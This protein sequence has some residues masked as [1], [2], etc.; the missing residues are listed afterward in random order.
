MKNDITAG[1]FYKGHEIL[2]RL[3]GAFL[4]SCE[5]DRDRDRYL[6]FPRRMRPRLREVADNQSDLMRLIC[7][8]LAG[9]TEGQVRQIYARFFE[10][11][12]AHFGM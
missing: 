11:G 5:A 1:V 9:L 7:D 2:D 4:G 12:H 6:L 10:P 3:F 8:Y